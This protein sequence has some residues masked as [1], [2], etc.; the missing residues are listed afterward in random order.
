[1]THE[2]ALRLIDSFVS[3]ELAPEDAR[4]LAEHLR[5]CSSCSAQMASASRL[6]EL[7]ATLPDVPPTPDFDERVLLAAL[8]DRRRRHAHR[9]P[10][11][12]LWT[13]IVRG[14]M[15][16]TGTLVLTVIVVAVL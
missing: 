11:A 12:D 9:H 16:T 2:T 14:A 13:Q 15:R 6:V 1:M 5:G 10:M 4:A 7:L 8:E 3:D